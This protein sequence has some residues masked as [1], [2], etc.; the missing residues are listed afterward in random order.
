M[1]RTDHPQSPA[2]GGKQ[3][4]ELGKGT[5]EVQQSPSLGSREG[6]AQCLALASLA[7]VCPQGDVPAEAQRAAPSQAWAALAVFPLLSPPRVTQLPW[8]LV[9]WDAVPG[10]GCGGQR[11]PQPPASPS[12]SP[13][14]PAQLCHT[15]TSAQPGEVQPLNPHWAPALDPTACS[16]GPGRGDR[17]APPPRGGWG[18]MSCILLLPLTY[19]LGFLES[20]GEVRALRRLWGG[21]ALTFL[22]DLRGAVVGMEQRSLRATS[23]E[24]R[25][26]HAWAAGREV[27]TEVGR[28]GGRRRGVSW[29]DGAALCP[30][31]GVRPSWGRDW[32]TAPMLGPP[33]PPA[34]T[35]PLAVVPGKPQE[36]W[37]LL[38]SRRGPQG[39]QGD[40]E[41]GEGGEHLALAKH[42]CPVP[43]R[44]KQELAA[45]PDCRPPHPPTPPAA[46][47]P[48][49]LQKSARPQRGRPIAKARAAPRHVGMT[50]GSGTLPRTG[51]GR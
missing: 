46:A 26:P 2:T 43:S 4:S 11:Q 42:P 1:C 20:E 18:G 21:P 34:E 44:G 15:T 37:D 8:P 22:P 12:P 6:Q 50:G 45:H 47:S 31:Q 35:Q 30:C 33:A 36:E 16:P 3:G 38:G 41:E 39:R 49:L 7:V 10:Q 9:L 29:R 32:S 14:A 40:L 23:W 19:F 27:G 25:S 17:A 5:T 51:G 13:G 24:Q 48:L 28:E